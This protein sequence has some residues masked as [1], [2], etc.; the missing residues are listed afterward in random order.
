MKRAYPY[1]IF[2]VILLLGAGGCDEKQRILLPAPD[3]VRVAFQDWIAP[4]PGYAGTRD[5]VIK[6]SPYWITRNGNFGINQ[7]DT[8]GTIFR[9]GHY[10]ER[11]LLVRSD[12][13]F[14]TDCSVVLQ[15]RL[16]LR[17]KP[18]GAGTAT[19]RLFETVVPVI[20]P[21][22]WVEGL[23]G[24]AAGASW[25]ATD[26]IVPWLTEGGDYLSPP[27][28]ECTV[29]EDSVITFNI[30]TGLIRRWLNDPATNHGVL[31]KSAAAG[32][33]AFREIY[34]REAGDS[35]LGPRL[36]IKYLRGG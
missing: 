11:R 8:L 30:S 34:L 2:P 10:Y 36:E 6:E 32:E 9:E 33:E 5:A 7:E 22:S 25:Y 12:I 1:I 35:T 13:T 27:L 16:S 20:V 26:G 17:I 31:I 29:D 4:F 23:G 18:G 21:G 15:A 19:F 24:L 3:T 14:I 28:D